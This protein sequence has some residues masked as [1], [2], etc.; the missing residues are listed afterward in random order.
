MKSLYP[1]YAFFKILFNSLTLQHRGLEPSVNY[2]L[3]LSGEILSV[4]ASMIDL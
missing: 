4:T 3:G 1:T 2:D